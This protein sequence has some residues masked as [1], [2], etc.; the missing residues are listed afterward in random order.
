M[1]SIIP[2]QGSLYLVLGRLR[3]FVIGICK[4]SLLVEVR[5]LR[6]LKKYLFGE[7]KY[8]NILERDALKVYIQ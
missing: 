6:C 4:K 7:K 3:W 2:N 8:K 5:T 1:S